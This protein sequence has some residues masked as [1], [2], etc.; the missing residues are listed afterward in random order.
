MGLRVF[1][2]L[3]A[4]VFFFGSGTFLG[5]WWGRVRVGRAS[6]FGSSATPGFWMFGGELLLSIKT[7][8]LYFYSVSSRLELCSGNLICHTL[9]S[10]LK[11]LRGSSLIMI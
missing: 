9:G 10:D 7:D 11:R 1:D 6:V 5:G 2:L 4:F 3:W 8:D